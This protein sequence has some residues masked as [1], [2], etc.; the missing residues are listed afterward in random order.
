MIKVKCATATIEEYLEAILNMISENKTVVGARL[1]ESLQVSP[2]TITAALQRMKRDGLIA[3]N[4][5]KE[6]SLTEKGFKLAIS[7]VRRHRLAERLL[8]DILKIPWSESHQ[9]ACLLEHGI[10]DKVME[11]LYQV[12]GKPDK[13]P[14]GNPIPI[15]NSMPPIR[16]IPLDT[17]IAGKTTVV[18]RISEE[19]NRH[20]GLMDYFDKSGVKPGAII[21]VLEVADY[22]GTMSLQIKNTHLAFGTRAAS[23]VWVIPQEG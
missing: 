4:E 9:D 15:N 2:P 11:K 14:H 6:V 22:A 19:A 3:T 21:K 10:S 13:C 8:T 1:A 20:L 16:G 17:V 18:E 7:M 12:L 23:L 5:R